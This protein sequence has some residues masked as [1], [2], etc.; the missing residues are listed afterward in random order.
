M[1]C[2][3]CMSLTAADANTEGEK[4]K[5]EKKRS[6]GAIQVQPHFTHRREADGS[7]LHQRLL[8]LFYSC[9]FTSEEL[10]GHG[11]IRNKR[12]RT[13]IKLINA[14]AALTTYEG[15]GSSGKLHQTAPC[16]QCTYKISFS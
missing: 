7:S 13:H 11:H 3:H 2:N 14:W 9:R 5:R 6:Q 1:T 15:W 10:N 16:V 4:K 12:E 8:S